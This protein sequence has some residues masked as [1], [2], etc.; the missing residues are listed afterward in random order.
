MAFDA[1]RLV[2]YLGWACYSPEDA[3]A[4]A[5]SLEAPTDARADGQGVVW[6]LTAAAGTPQA[7]D[8]MLAQGRA[9]YGGWRVMG[10]RHRRNGRIVVFDQPIRPRGRRPLVGRIGGGQLAMP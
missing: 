5:R 2:G 3:A 4:Y 10:V 8:A 1:S 6:L 9:R 7:L